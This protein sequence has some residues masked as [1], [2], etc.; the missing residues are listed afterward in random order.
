MTERSYDVV[1]VGAG[2]AG[3]ACAV[4]AARQ[5]V[6]VALI[7]KEMTPG[8]ILT[9]GGNNAIDQFNNP[10]KKNKK[11]I[12]KGIAYELVERL[13]K[14]GFAFV[15]DMYA[16]R[17][18]HDQYSVKVNPTATA[19]VMDEMLLSSGVALYYGQPVVSVETD[20]RNVSAA[21]ISTKSGLKKICGKIFVDCSGDGDFA[22]WAGAKCSCG[23][24]DKT[25]QPGT[26][27]VYPA[28]QPRDDDKVLNYGDN[29]NHVVLNL[30]SDD[31]TTSNVFAR[32]E[33]YNQML[34]G[35]KIMTT[36][37]A[38]APREGRRI[39]GITE[40][41]ANDYLSGKIFHDSVCYSFWFV[42]IHR[43]DQPAVIKYVE[44][45]NTPT[46]P[47]S[48]MT[49]IDFDNLMMAGRNISTDRATNSAIR[50]KAS[51]MAMGEAVGV[52]CA[53]FV[54][55]CAEKTSEIDV[56]KVKSILNSTGAIVPDYCGGVD[57]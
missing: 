41:N 13:Q 52:A 29:E 35:R 18:K 17:V 46:I 9:V 7:E 31:L 27:R 38:V 54:K 50:V 33:V 24:E 40:L 25:F 22:F 21:I 8:G 4:A 12:I 32:R 2:S 56:N 23:G 57:F 1:I 55:S 16:Q 11:I 5:N 37:P 26:L 36:A 6:K 28:V 47:L 53:V 42:D 48:A 45:E 19:V 51:C 10:F 43:K 49:A 14:D 15:P 3:F 44:S 34:K 39:K 30:D 20:G